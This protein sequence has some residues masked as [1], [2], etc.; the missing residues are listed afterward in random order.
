M[1]SEPA[2]R[3]AWGIVLALSPRL[4]LRRC[5]RTPSTPAGRMVVRALGVRHVLQGITTARDAVPPGWSAVPD[6]LHAAS[7]AG[8]ALRSDRWRAAALGDCCVACAFALASL[9]AAR[10][11]RQRSAGRGP[12]G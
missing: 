10:R 8:L 5:P 9:Q 3:V 7:M 12:A 11:G 4:V 6:A 2:V 1:V